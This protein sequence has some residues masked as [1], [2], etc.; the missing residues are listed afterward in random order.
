MSEHQHKAESGAVEHGLVDHLRAALRQNLARRPDYHRRGG[1][2]AWM[3]SVTLVAHER[4]ILPFAAFLDR[5]ARP[6]QR[7][8]IP[9][10]SADLQPMS[11]SPPPGRQL[12]A[13]VPM[14]A[15]DLAWVRSSLRSAR[16]AARAALRRKDLRQAALELATALDEVEAAEAR[17]GARLALTAHVL[18]SAGVSAANGVT[19]A[20]RSD[21]RT[22]PLSRRFV[23]GQLLLLPGALR[24][25]ALAGPVH[26][27]G[28][29]ILIDDVPPV[30]FRDAL[31]QLDA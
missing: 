29:P 10:L 15:E 7:E 8:G 11:L 17:S 12:E 14:G 26:A 19:Y 5:Q 25:D 23:A 4:S 9:I 13:V 30:P 6:F 31:R 16:R 1:R 24:L 20:E 28:V 2:R 3:L 27:R 18:E 22:L 21:E